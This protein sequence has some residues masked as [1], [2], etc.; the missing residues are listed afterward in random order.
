MTNHTDLERDLR[1]AGRAFDDVAM[2]ADAWQQNQHRLAASR[3]Q[4]TRRWLSVA[5]A[6]IVALLIGTVA[7]FADRGPDAGPPAHQGS[8]D[9]FATENLLGPV[10]ELETVTINGERAVHEAVLSDS[11]GTGPS[12]CDQY[13][14]TSSAAGGCTSREPNADDDAIAFDWLSGSGGSGDQ[15][16]IVAGVDSRVSTVRVW[17]DDGEERVLSLEPGTWQDSLLTG[18]TLP[19][20]EAVPQRLVAYGHN[21]EVLQAVDLPDRFGDGW[22]IE[23]SAC[24]GDRIAESVPAGDVLPNAYLA[25]GTDD[26]RISIRLAQDDNAEAC[27]ERLRA[28][29][30]SGWYPGGTLVAVV[31]APEVTTV[32]LIVAGASGSDRVLDEVTPKAVEGSPWRVAML[33]ADR[34]RLVDDAELVA[35]D[36]TGASLDRAF[37]NGAPPAD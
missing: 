9:P 22:L 4:R 20:H 33:R 31:T 8:D 11:N 3:S 13:L 30:L 2:S 16:G 5:A 24:A 37:V 32:R 7:V 18:L 35:L 12:L 26:A 28:A 27:V 23:R 6:V 17:L 14:A 21:N 10:V 36:Q 29:A 25:L 1:A 19:A 15:H 34:Q